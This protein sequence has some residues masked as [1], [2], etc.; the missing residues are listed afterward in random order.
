MSEPK[1]FKKGKHI[2][3]RWGKDIKEVKTMSE[4]EG[5]KK[6]AQLQVELDDNTAQGVYANI[7]FITHTETE[8]VMD[9]IYAQPQQPKAKVRARVIS[10]P[11]HTKK[12]LQALAASVNKYEKQFGEI[13]ISSE[14][15]K[16]IGFGNA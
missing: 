1:Q 13:K 2:Y 14:A 10:S 4:T 11:V 3:T 12:L 7:A 6:N 9:F 8:F 16:K 5:E 15:E